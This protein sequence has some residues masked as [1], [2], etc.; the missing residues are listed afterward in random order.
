MS[1]L[2]TL[3]KRAVLLGLV[4]SCHYMRTPFILE[5]ANKPAT[6]G[7]PH[8]VSVQSRV[9]TL[10]RSHLVDAY[11]RPETVAG[12]MGAFGR[13]PRPVVDLLSCLD[14]VRAGTVD[15]CHRIFMRTVLPPLATDGGAGPVAPWGMPGFPA[16]A[17][18]TA[19]AD[20]A[21]HRPEV[22]VEID[23]ERFASN[24]WAIAPSLQQLHRLVGAQLTPE[25]LVAGLTTG[26]TDA[27]AYVSARRWHRSLDRHSTAL[28]LSGGSA[29]GAFTAG[30][31]W[32]LMEVLQACN[33]PGGACA[34]FKLDLVT[35]TSTGA[36]IAV[37]ID[38]FFTAGNQD[39]ARQVLFDSYTCSV[40]SKLYCVNDAYDWKLAD[41]LKG[42]VRF[43][44]IRQMLVNAISPEMADNGTELVT[45]SVDMETGDLYADSDQDPADRA[46]LAGRPDVVLASIVQPVLAE[47]IDGLP[48]VSGKIAGSFVDGGV[49]SGLSVM[50]AVRRGADRVLVLSVSGLDPGRAPPQANAFQML[51]RAVGVA[52]DQNVFGELQL[53]EL[54][55]VARRMGEHEVCANRFA[56][57]G[58]SSN[59]DIREFCE[60][61]SIF[62]RPTTGAEAA[63][64]SWYGPM[65]FREVAESWKSEWVLRPEGAEG[66]TG[67]AFEPKVMRPLFELGLRTF[68][69]RCLGVMNL[70]GL[71]A[72]AATECAKDPAAVVAAAKARYQTMEIC[73][74]GLDEIRKCP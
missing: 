10:A 2:L 1:N 69:E 62:T 22:E 60:R 72:V 52:T 27:A 66:S 25:V 47:P 18:A 51:F 15:G 46:P 42:L 43:D 29:N 32:R 8:D 49:R 34:D 26:A 38:Q 28:V 68:Q 19:L 64:A 48:R 70:L 63:V 71:Q 55:A 53:S 50:E 24:A 9:R 36:L 45:V 23:A 21:A 4:A 67:Y 74:K 56:L 37:L 58:G 33:R 35:G 20:P 7:Q 6:T 13:N 39:R 59:R 30:F 40:P 31:V 14:D 17:G 44:G 11:L 57:L 5:Q 73:N 16:G 54:A 3:S 61:R 41:N 65:L 12:W